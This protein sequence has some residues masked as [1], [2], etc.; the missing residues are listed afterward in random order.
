MISS[1]ACG[2]LS[3]SS[4]KVVLARRL[5]VSPR[6]SLP[7]T[8]TFHLLDG[9]GDDDP[10]EYLFS[11]APFLFGSPR[12]FVH[13]FINLRLGGRKKVEARSFCSSVLNELA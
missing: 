11:L 12:S 9:G 8:F 7:A 4:A 5:V 13:V 1:A 6:R 3:S 2:G 10:R